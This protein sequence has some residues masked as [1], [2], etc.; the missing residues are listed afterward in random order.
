MDKSWRISKH[1]QTCASFP[2]EPIHMGL[3]VPWANQAMEAEIPSLFP[4]RVVWHVAR[5]VP[6]SATTALDDTF[7]AGMVQALPQALFQLHHLP[8]RAFAFGCTSASS[9]FPEEITAARQAYGEDQPEIPFL[10]AFSAL[11]LCL[12]L[13]QAKRMLLLAPYESALTQREGEAFTRRGMTVTTAISLGYRDDIGTIS[14]QQLLQACDDLPLAEGDA[15]VL[16]CTALHTLECIPHL[17]ERYHLPVL[18]SN[19]A[20]ALACVLSATGQVSW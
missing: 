4:G 6:A 18:S 2:G 17:E 15:L 9:L 14:S 20:L 7:L 3:L 12:T 13:C 5:L 16:S 11:C 8:L 19:T 10:T 1:L